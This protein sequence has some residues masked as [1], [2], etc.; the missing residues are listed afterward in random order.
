MMGTFFHNHTCQFFVFY[1][2]THKDNSFRVLTRFES[3]LLVTLCPCLFINFSHVI[4]EVGSTFVAQYPCIMEN[5]V[6]YI[7]DERK[8]ENPYFAWLHFCRHQLSMKESNCFLK[9]LINNCQ[10]VTDL[11]NNGTFIYWT[12]LLAC[13]PW[14]R[15]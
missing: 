10:S 5:T 8:M 6:W 9:L 3:L 12:A 15:P 2:K 1:L 14:S 11:L 7:S 4:T 13:L